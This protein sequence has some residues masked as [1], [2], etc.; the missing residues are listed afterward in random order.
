M[1]AAPALQNL[2]LS[3]TGSYPAQLPYFWKNASLLEMAQS[4]V[5]QSAIPG[6][7]RK[8]LGPF[9]SLTRFKMPV[10]TV[11]SRVDSRSSRVFEASQLH[12]NLSRPKLEQQA[13][14]THSHTHT[15]HFLLFRVAPDLVPHLSAAKECL[16]TYPNLQRPFR[17]GSSHGWHCLVTYHTLA[18]IMVQD[19]AKACKNQAGENDDKPAAMP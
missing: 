9:T 4:N 11:Q 15:F 5:G 12:L 7:L 13:Q 14:E 1:N 6:H 10:L 3:K 19:C 18:D 17:G 16:G 2:R 8:N